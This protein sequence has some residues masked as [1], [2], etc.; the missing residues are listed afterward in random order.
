MVGSD[1]PIDTKFLGCSNL[2]A[3]VTTGLLLPVKIENHWGTNAPYQHLS[4]MS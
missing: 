3:G 2:F 1:L 4:T